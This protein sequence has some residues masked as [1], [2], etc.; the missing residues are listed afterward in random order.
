MLGY[1]PPGC[2]CCWVE[3]RCVVEKESDWLGDGHCDSDIGLN[4]PGCNYDNG[5]CCPQTCVSTPGNNCRDT[6]FNCL[7][8]RYEGCKYFQ[9]RLLQC[10]YFV[11]V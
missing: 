6:G 1:N 4:T 5:D 3:P 11:K 8:P 2:L 7:D 9:Q 10:F